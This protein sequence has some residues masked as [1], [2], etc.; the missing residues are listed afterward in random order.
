MANGEPMKGGRDQEQVKALINNRFGIIPDAVEFTLTNRVI[1]DMIL[2]VFEEAGADTSQDVLNLRCQWNREFDS[3]IREHKKDAKGIWPFYVEIAVRADSDSRKQPIT[4]AQKVL[5]KLGQ[6]V[7]DN[8][9]KAQVNILNSEELNKAISTFNSG[10]KIKWKYVSQRKGILKTRL[11][12]MDVLNIGFSLDLDPAKRYSFDLDIIN[13]LK[14]GRK[15]DR[16]PSKFAIIIRKGFRAKDFKS[17]KS[18]LFDN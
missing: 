4:P 18:S 8:D 15:I 6:V 5:R 10:N 17:T 2:D 9:I 13:V 12:T 14:L 11:D 16:E 7:N 1:Q 3:V